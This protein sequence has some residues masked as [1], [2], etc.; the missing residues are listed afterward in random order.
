MFMWCLSSMP[1]RVW[2]SGSHTTTSASAPGATMPLRGYMPNMRAGVVQQVSTHRSRVSW[3]LTTPW[4][5]SSMRCSTPPMPLGILEKSPSP[6]SFWSLKQN[7]Q[8]SVETIVR[9]FVRS[10]RQRLSW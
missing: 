3:P 5:S 6:S 7:G 1:I 4:Y 10:P 2:E 9:S 8:W